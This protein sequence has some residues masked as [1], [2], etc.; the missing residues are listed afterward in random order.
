MCNHIYNHI[1]IDIFIICIEF[2]RRSISLSSEKILPFL[3]CPDPLRLG[4]GQLP[5]LSVELSGHLKVSVC[6][7]VSLGDCHGDFMKISWI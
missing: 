7:S 6:L 5:I 2:Y 4:Q 1:Y 3:D